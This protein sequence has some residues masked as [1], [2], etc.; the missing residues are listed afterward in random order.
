[1]AECVK[2]PYA[3]DHS[4]RRTDCTP[5]D[6]QA[7][8]RGSGGQRRKSGLRDRPARGGPTF[9]VRHIEIAPGSL[10]PS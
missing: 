8:Q 4:Q 7:D 5:I 10:Q 1:M 9:P 3:C 2:Q 6:G